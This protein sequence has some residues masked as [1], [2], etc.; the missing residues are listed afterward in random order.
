MSKAEDDDDAQYVPGPVMEAIIESAKQAEG[1]FN[2]FVQKMQGD[3]GNVIEDQSIEV[4]S[5]QQAVTPDQEVESAALFLA[6][7]RN[8]CM[9]ITRLMLHMKSKANVT[10]SFDACNLF[11][12]KL[13]Q[14]V[15]E[16]AIE[17]GDNSVH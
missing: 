2:N 3:G 16:A 5:A 1:L 6:A 17:S 12:Q 11:M 15:Y 13:N 7:A 10:L 9:L 4:F 14:T 8:N